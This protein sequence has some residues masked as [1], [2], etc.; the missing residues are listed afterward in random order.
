MNISEKDIC[1][2]Q[3]IYEKKY[4]EK[5]SFEQATKLGQALISIYFIFYDP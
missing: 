1:K 4:G 2:L 5:I 3:A